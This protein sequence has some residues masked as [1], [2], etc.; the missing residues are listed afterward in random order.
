MDF[1]ALTAYSMSVDRAQC[2]SSQR[3]TRMKICMAQH[4]S[5]NSPLVIA[6]ITLPHAAVLAP[7]SGI[8]DLPFRRAVRR[9]G[10]GLMVTEMVASAAVLQQVRGEMRKLKTTAL[11]EVPLSIQLAYSLRKQLRFFES[12]ACQY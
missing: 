6:G 5:I 3:K 9:C 1:W 12:Q 4:S 10:G 8:T 7:M 2:R 11:E